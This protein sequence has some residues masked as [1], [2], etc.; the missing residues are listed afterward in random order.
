MAATSKGGWSGFGCDR[1]AALLPRR[2][3]PSLSP[4]SEFQDTMGGKCATR[5]K[6]AEGY[7]AALLSDLLCESGVGR[8]VVI[9]VL[10]GEFCM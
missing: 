1:F 4:A 6:T 2:R 8:G 10:D 5:S 3:T 7:C 9:S